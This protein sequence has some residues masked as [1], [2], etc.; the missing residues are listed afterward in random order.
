[1]IKKAFIAGG[2][3]LVLGMLVNQFTQAL[4]P[5]LTQEYQNTAVFRP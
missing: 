2:V 5:S 1:M 3:I 4:F